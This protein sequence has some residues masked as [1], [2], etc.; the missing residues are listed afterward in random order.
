MRHRFIIVALAL[1]AT[2]SLAQDDDSR[3]LSTSGRAAA[4]CL[5]QYQGSVERCRGAGAPGCE[6]LLQAE[7]GPLDAWLDR[8]RTAATAHCGEANAAPLGF[9]SLADIGAKADDACADWAEDGLDLAFADAPLNS[10]A[11]A[12]CQRTVAAAL[13]VL[14]RS[15]LIAYGPQCYVPAFNGTGCDHAARDARV[16]L[17]RRKAVRLIVARCGNAFDE[18]HLTPADGGGLAE[19]VGD[20]ADTA[21]TRAKHF[22]LR[23]Y[24]PNDL[25]PT[26]D[27]GP[28]PVGIT[29]LQLTDASRMNTAGDGPR[30]VTVEVYYP[31]TAAAIAGH[32]RDVATVL[33][34]PL[35]E[36][37]AYRDVAMAADGPYPLVLF[38]HGNNGI[39]IQSFFFGAHLASHGYIV[40][41]PDHHGNTF[42]DT[43]AGLFDAQVAINRPRDMRFLIDTFLEF[44]ASPAG[45]FA[46]AIDPDRIGMSGHSFG[47]YTTFALG[48]GEFAEPRVKAL[49][50]QAPAAVFD[51]AFF[52]GITQPTLIIGGSIDETTPPAENQQRPF[53]ALPSGARVVAYANLS[54]AGHFTFSDFCEVPRMLLSFLGGFSEACEPRHLPWRHA[55]DITNYLALNFFD[56]TLRDDAA[57]LAR[58]SPQA[59]G[60][61]ED[62]VYQTK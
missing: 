51:D 25:G 56:A 14:S 44:N 15:T 3:C 38:S 60:T 59:V 10:P 4:M 42:P 62:V 61:I 31:T 46:G 50:P 19:R 22:A 23:V 9:L 8:A 49:L 34:I 54:G 33:G 17:A 36:T 6:E 39:R 24:P 2:R 1:L 37:P 53:D 45:F 40:V 7:D 57:A 21:I 28:Y 48:N 43:L 47:G 20:L 13:R 16:A 5:L 58:L 32:P 18:L 55:H 12:S 52:A 26:A 41:S 35:L 30:P 29:T 11:A 27:F